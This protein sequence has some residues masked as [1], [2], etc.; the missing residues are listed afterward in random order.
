MWAEHLTTLR[1]AGAGPSGRPGRAGGF[2]RGNARSLQTRWVLLLSTLI[3]ETV[4]GA[5]VGAHSWSLVALEVA[6]ALAGLDILR[7]VVPE[8]DRYE[9]GATAEELVGARLETLLDEGWR[10]HHDVPLGQGNVDHV[11]IGPGGVFTVETKSTPRPVQVR[12]IHGRLLAQAQS[13]SRRVAALLESAAAGPEP[14]G[15]PV[16]PL[17]VFTRAEI[18]RPGR[19]RKGVRALPAD[20]LVPWL[21]HRRPALDAAQV[22][23]LDARLRDAAGR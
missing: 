12:E 15:P 9:R 21:R 14:A 11:V 2:V 8:I 18:D 3:G 23:A 1:P 19:R 10:V 7:Q 16:E 13:E 4:F 5:L 22:L 20:G 6:G 17:L